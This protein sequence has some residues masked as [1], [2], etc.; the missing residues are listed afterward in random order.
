LPQD[1]LEG[2]LNRWV[3]A[4][5]FSHRFANKLTLDVDYRL[6]D[7]DNATEQNTYD[8]VVGD[9]RPAFVARA[10]PG[11]DFTRQELGTRL[12][13][14]LTSHTR[15]QGGAEVS[16]MDRRDRAV[17]QADELTLWS[18]LRWR[19]LDASALSLRA[20]RS[21]RRGDDYA[22]VP[23]IE[24]PQ[25]PL[26]RK[27]S[28][29]DQDRFSLQA[30]ASHPLTDRLT[31]GAQIRTDRIDY[32]DTRIGLTDTDETALSLDLTYAPGGDWSASLFTG[33][34]HFDSTQQGSAA[35]AEPDWQ[36]RIEDTAISLGGAFD[37]HPVDGRW[38]TGVEFSLVDG[39][40]D[41]SVTDTP[42]PEVGADLLRLVYRSSYRF[43]DTLRGMLELW[44]ERYK[45]QDWAV[46]N[47]A[48]DSVDRTLGLGEDARDH[49]AVA[50][51][52]TLRYAF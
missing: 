7:L 27:Y 17:E 39:Q 3:A 38:E 10:N 40:S 11:F 13:Y 1:S 37:W 33:F 52:L 22:V 30:T 45:E 20:E 5:R 32:P 2:E 18:G 46:E 12:S 50:A 8:Y 48:A 47:V 25:N 44:Y 6:E 43:N 9:F 36:A 29:A 35:F 14:P 26:M 23:N 24:P 31:L 51:V 16:R 4:T 34:N 19:L 21:Y 15:L 49:E 28:M 42:F 41:I